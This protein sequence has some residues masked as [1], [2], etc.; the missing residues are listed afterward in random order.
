LRRDDRIAL[1]QFDTA[2]EALGFASGPK[3]AALAKGLAGPR[4][5]TDLDQAVSKVLASGATDIL[6]LTDGQTWSATADALRTSKARIS[7]ILV[8][9][10]SLDVNIGQ[11]CAQ[12]GGQLFYAAGDDVAAPL[13]RAF[14]AL[15]QTG[16]A[17]EGL[18]ADGYPSALTARRGGIEI[19]ATWSEAMEMTGADAV[20]RYAAALALPLLS[21]EDADAWAAAHTLCTHRTSLILIDEVGDAVDA[22]PEMRK[23]ALT[24][25]RVETLSVSASY[26]APMFAER[27]AVPR[28][29]PIRRYESSASA[30]M[31]ASSSDTSPMARQLPDAERLMDRTQAPIWTVALRHAFRDLAWDV[32]AEQFLAGDFS[33][34]IKEQSMLIQKLP[35]SDKISICA[36]AHGLHPTLVALALVAEIMGDRLALR[37]TR[38]VFKGIGPSEW[39]GLKLQGAGK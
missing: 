1:W 36:A 17:A 9:A 15:R 24:S 10:G 32:A 23:I 29:S 14:S 38:R 20:G 13:A 34:L 11:L 12:T 25:P 6:V 28:K 3:A 16:G 27:A 33:V 26:S 4:G 7:A 5:G 35:T 19:T 18:C 21:T 30:S 8:G 31:S 22:L 37:F 39:A 2:C